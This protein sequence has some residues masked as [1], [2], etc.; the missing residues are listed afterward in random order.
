MAS[1]QDPRLAELKRLQIALDAAIKHL[2]EFD[3]QAF[4]S[5]QKIRTV[6]ASKRSTRPVEN[7][8]AVQVAAGLA[9]FRQG[10]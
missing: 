1:A 2:D 8:F 5:M 10:H 4:K 7:G 3:A 6:M 9:R